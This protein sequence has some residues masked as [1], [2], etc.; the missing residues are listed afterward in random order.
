MNK[1]LYTAISSLQFISQIFIRLIISYQIFSL[2]PFFDRSNLVVLVFVL[3]LSIYLFLV[4][5]DEIIV[6]EDRITQ[7]NNSFYWAIF[8]RK[9]YV[10]YIDELMYAYIES[11]SAPYTRRILALF[12]LNLHREFPNNRGKSIYFQLK[13][14]A[15]AKFDTNLE[16]EKVEEIIEIVN[17]LTKHNNSENDV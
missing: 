11:D 2:S 9:G 4:G 16:N 8:R 17:S 7:T 12:T 6:Y 14:G 5:D 1:K 10:V 13:D 15:I 3:L